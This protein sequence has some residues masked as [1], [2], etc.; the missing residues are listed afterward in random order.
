ME[1]FEFMGGVEGDEVDQWEAQ[2]PL[3]HIGG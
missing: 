2:Q 1:D 3:K